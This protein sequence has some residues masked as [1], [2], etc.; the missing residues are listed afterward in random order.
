MTIALIT[1]GVLYTI[2]G[3][4]KLESPSWTSGLGI[5]Y[6][7]QNSFS[8]NN[9][10]TS[11][12]LSLPL[13]IQK[14]IGWVFLGAELL[15]LPAFFTHRIVKK[16]TWIILTLMHGGIFLLMNIWIVTVPMLIFHLLVFD[17]HWFK[18]EHEFAKKLLKRLK[19]KKLTTYR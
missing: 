4:N 11:I 8:N 3:L 19:V 7:L 2:S 16:Y 6:S 1:L 9:F 17:W 18:E 5:I 15:C 10:I 13:I 12:T 14:I